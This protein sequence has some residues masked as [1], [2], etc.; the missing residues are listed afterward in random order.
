MMPDRIEPNVSF[1]LITSEDVELLAYFFE[2]LSDSTRKI[3]GFSFTREL[4]EQWVNE[5]TGDPNMRRYMVFEQPSDRSADSVML[6]TVWLWKWTK[7]VVW[8]GIM[9]ADAYQNKGYGSKLI[10]IAVEDAKKSNK[11]GIL[12]STH[13]TNLRAQKLY[14]K[15]DFQIIGED[16][17]G[18]YLM[19]LNFPV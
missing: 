17:R 1:R 10:E 9:I 15:H 14:Q 3:Y 13:K 18:E 6:G 16:L 2:S 7:Q 5:G 19:L 11:G 12:L 8:F 4:A